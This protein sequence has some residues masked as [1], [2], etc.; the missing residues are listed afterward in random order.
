MVEC[1]S[2]HAAMW[3]LC[4]GAREVSHAR[5]QRRHDGALGPTPARAM[6]CCAVIRLSLGPTPR[7]LPSG[8]RHAAVAGAAEG[9]A[10][11]WA[12]RPAAA[13]RDDTTD[14]DV[15]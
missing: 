1:G 3:A 7:T 9:C 4:E 6:G 12:A 2:A 5:P 11:D 8:K 10:D 14:A 15:A 13:E